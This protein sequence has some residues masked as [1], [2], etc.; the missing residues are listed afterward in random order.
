MHNGLLLHGR[1]IVISMVRENTP[2]TPRHPQMQSVDHG[3]W[4]LGIT[5]LMNRMVKQCHRCAQEAAAHRESMITQSS[6]HTPGKRLI[7]TCSN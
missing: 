3:V 4:L 1:H 2:R 5:A 7:Q 6:P